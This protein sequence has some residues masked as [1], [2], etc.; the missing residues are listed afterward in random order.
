MWTKLLQ[1]SLSALAGWFVSDVYN[2]YQTTRQMQPAVV[3]AT[4]KN[5]LKWIVIGVGGSIILLI[6]SR[7]IRIL[8]PKTNLLPK[9]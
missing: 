3:T 8:F 1:L 6:L 5:W 2:E 7:I 9:K 4:K